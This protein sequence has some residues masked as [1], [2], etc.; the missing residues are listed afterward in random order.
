[1]FLATGLRRLTVEECAILQGFP[2]NYPW[3]AARTKGQRYAAV[4]NAVPP[5]LAQ[6]V[7]RC[8]A[9]AIEERAALRIGDSV[10]SSCMVEALHLAE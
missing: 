9:T 7:A 6:A 2:V 3:S 4:G 1:V 10:S 5:A 8:I